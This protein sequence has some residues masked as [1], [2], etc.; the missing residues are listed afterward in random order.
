MKLSLDAQQVQAWGL[1]D[2]KP[3]HRALMRR[4]VET[5]SNLGL[6]WYVASWRDNDRALLG[7]LSRPGVT[8]VDRDGLIKRTLEARRTDAVIEALHHRSRDQIRLLWHWSLRGKQDLFW[9]TEMSFDG[10][11]SDAQSLSQWLRVCVRL[12]KTNA[13]NNGILDGIE[14]PRISAPSPH[15]I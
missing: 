6:E 2:L 13:G 5:H 3:M 7:L 12:G 10:V 8:L 9:C 14:L 1:L 11:I 4:T 15:T